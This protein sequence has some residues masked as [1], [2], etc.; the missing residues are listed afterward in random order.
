MSYEIFEEQEKY[1]RLKNTFEKKYPE[2][3]DLKYA[4]NVVK[5]ST[6]QKELRKNNALL[7]Y[8]IFKD[9]LYVFTVRKSNFYLRK[10]K[11]KYPV[12][13]LVKS[14]RNSL[15]NLDYKGYLKDLV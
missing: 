13:D 6:L 12:N 3:H 2:Y 14:L 1:D 8:Y 11:L 5:V 9:K 4:K 10:I 15:L 7:E